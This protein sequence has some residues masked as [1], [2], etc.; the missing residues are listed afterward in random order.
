MLLPVSTAVFTVEASPAGT[1]PAAARAVR[2]ARMARAISR[3]TEQWRLHRPQPE[4]RPN[5]ASNHSAAS[6][7][8]KSRAPIQAGAIRPSEPGAAAENRID[9]LQLVGGDVARVGIG[10]VVVAGLGAQPAADAAGQVGR[11]AAVE[12]GVQGLPRG[13]QRLGRQL[14]REIVRDGP[15]AFVVRHGAFAPPGGKA[16]RRPMKAPSMARQ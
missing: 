8:S 1:A 11:H 5:R 2:P 4:Q 9:Q 14:G 10:Q 7:L 6:A 12:R 13:L 16:P 15:G 3:P